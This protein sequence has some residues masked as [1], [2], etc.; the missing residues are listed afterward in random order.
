M[1]DVGLSAMV[2]TDVGPPAA[3][4]LDLILYGAY[5]CVGR[6]AALHLANKTTTSLRLRWAIAGRNRT[7]LAALAEVSELCIYFR[8]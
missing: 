1:V 5:G 2:A 8:W 6:I 3:A 4:D 7:K